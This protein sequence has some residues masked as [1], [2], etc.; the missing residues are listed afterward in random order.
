[1]ALPQAIQRLEDEA[2]AITQQMQT[3]QTD[4]E[5]VV[6]D[7]SQLTPANE[8]PVAPQAAPAQPA[9]TPAPSDDGY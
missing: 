4:A 1:M 9:P 2:N 6:T 3:Q 7:A 5:P 8:A